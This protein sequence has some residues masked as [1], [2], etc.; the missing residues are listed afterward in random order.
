VHLSQTLVHGYLLVRPRAGLSCQSTPDPRGGTEKLPE[1]SKAARR[2]VRCDGTYHF[3]SWI[4][5]RRSHL[6]ERHRESRA[7]A[8]RPGSIDSPQRNPVRTVIGL[9]DVFLVVTPAA[10]WLYVG[11]P[12]A[13]AQGQRDDVV[14]RKRSVFLSASK[15]DVSVLFAKRLE[16]CGGIRT[17][18]CVFPGTPPAPLRCGSSRIALPPTTDASR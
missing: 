10:Q 2:T 13:G 15:A 7:S 12:I 16:L 18:S 11:Y 6:L 3:E 17:F 1:L 8:Q 4:K 9:S 5:P 14:R